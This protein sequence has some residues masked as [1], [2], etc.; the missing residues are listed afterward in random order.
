MA[1]DPISLGVGSALFTLNQL[2]N[3]YLET[4]RRATEQ[5]GPENI[6]SYDKILVDNKTLQDKIDAEKVNP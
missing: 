3:L 2:A 1:V 5:Y 4:H 6:P